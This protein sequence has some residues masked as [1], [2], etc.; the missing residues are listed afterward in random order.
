MATIVIETETQT[1]FLLV[2]SGFGAYMATRPGM[3]FG[4]LAPDETSGRLPMILV[5]NAGGE[6][7]WAESSDFEVLSVDGESPGDLL[8]RSDPG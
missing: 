1:R 7:F 2:G 8:A 6:L 5:S 3:F 4:N